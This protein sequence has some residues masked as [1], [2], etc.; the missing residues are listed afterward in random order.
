MCALQLCECIHVICMYMLLGVYVCTIRCVY[1]CA[2]IMRYMYMCALLYTHVSTIRCKYIIL[3]ASVT[4]L[5]VC[6]C[7]YEGGYVCVHSTFQNI[8]LVCHQ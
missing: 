3:C 6:V 8:P 1:T 7:V 2:L 4:L 5:I